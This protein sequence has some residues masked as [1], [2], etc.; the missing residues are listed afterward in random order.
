MR[1]VREFAFLVA[2]L[3]LAAVPLIGT[4]CDDQ[5][6]TKPQASGEPAVDVG[7]KADTKPSAAKP[8][9]KGR[10]SDE[11]GSTTGSLGVKPPKSP[12]DDTK[13]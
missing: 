8:K 6:A 13:K 12:T 7:K 1:L 3:S 11:S 9:K 10:A 5:G 4:G 2:I